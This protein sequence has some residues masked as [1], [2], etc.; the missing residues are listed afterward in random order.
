[1]KI[2]SPEYI[3]DKTQFNKITNELNSSKSNTVYRSFDET[4]QKLYSGIV[5]AASQGLDEYVYVVES[6]KEDTKRR[7]LH[8][9]RIAI[10]ESIFV[11]AKYTITVESDGDSIKLSI[12]WK[13]E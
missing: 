3:K 13:D 4:M 9:K 7:K 6:V 1:M 10:I 2:F 5:N 11:T 8:E 12:S